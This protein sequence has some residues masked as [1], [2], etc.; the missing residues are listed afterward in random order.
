[1][2]SLEYFDF[3]KNPLTGY[4]SDWK[5]PI[6]SEI[7]S[8]FKRAGGGNRWLDVNTL[9]GVNIKHIN[10]LPGVNI[11]HINT[12]PGVNIKHINTLPGVNIKQQFGKR[13][14]IHPWTHLL[15]LYYDVGD[16]HERKHHGT[17]E[18][19]SLVSVSLTSKSRL[20]SA[21]QCNCESSKR[22]RG[23]C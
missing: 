16:S 11:K 4:T 10:T 14:F 22:T 6:S 3:M 19:V 18:G 17:S 12:L 20:V 21:S 5:L 15:L 2:W 8:S 13:P 9:P 7:A 1:M 23:Q